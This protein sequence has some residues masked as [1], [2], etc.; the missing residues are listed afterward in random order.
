MITLQELKGCFFYDPVTGIFIRKKPVANCS[1]VGEIAGHRNK[2]GYII[3]KFRQRAYKAHRLA[4]FYMTGKWPDDQ[5]DHVNRD[6]SDN[7]F[8]N[9]READN[10]LNVHNIGIQKNNTSGFKGVSYDQ[11]LNKYRAYLD[12]RGKRYFLKLH[13]TALEASIARETKFEELGKA[14]S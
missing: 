7:R 4:W 14:A 12:Y 10:S 9:L 3:I 6:K 2:K 1:R 11:K 5:I 13:D 8:S